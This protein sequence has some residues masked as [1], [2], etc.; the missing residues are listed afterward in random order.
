MPAAG[1]QAPRSRA[2]SW[3]VGIA[4]AA[5]LLG[6]AFRGVDGGKVATLLHGLGGGAALLLVPSAMALGLETQ[7]WQGAFV[8]MGARPP[9]FRLLGVRLGSES[10]GAALPLGAMWADAVKPT[11]LAGRCGVPIPVGV[12]AIAAR[13][14]LL[15]LS[16]AGYLAI[17]FAIGQSALRKGFDHAAGAPA[18]AWLALVAS[19]ALFVSAYGM[20][21]MLRGGRAL[22]AIMR[23]MALMP[24]KRVRDRL[25]GL[26]ASVSHTDHAASLF[27]GATARARLP[28]ALRCLAAWLL[29]AT[30][31]CLIL[32]L[33]G[34]RVGWSDAVAI[35]GLVGLLRHVLV[36]LPGG[37]GA[38]ELGYTALLTGLGCGVD[39]CAAFV[40]LKRARELFWIAIGCAALSSASRLPAVTE[41]RPASAY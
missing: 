8:I 41:E 34:A 10:V 30:E 15:V 20:A 18:L 40:L 6:L 1:G 22:R 35:E 38:Q 36:V 11:L 17:G 2:L 24:V 26:S 39:T 32:R 28:L 16:Q 25:L 21:A 31:T 27:F 14:Y 5:A 3:A 33:L 23:A 29:E 4:L 13:K 19:L 37:L 9:F 7:A 12:A